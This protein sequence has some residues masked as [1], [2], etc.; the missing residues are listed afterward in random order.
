MKGFFFFN[1]SVLPHELNTNWNVA[2]GRE[3]IKAVC[4]CVRRS[5]Q[6]RECFLTGCYMFVFFPRLL[7]H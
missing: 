7:I 6:S 4:E 5:C 1:L 3:R 2:S